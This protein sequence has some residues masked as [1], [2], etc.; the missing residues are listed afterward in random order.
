MEAPQIIISEPP[1]QISPADSSPVW[2]RFSLLC[3]L[4]L[5]AALWLEPQMAPICR[6]TAFQV[7]ALLGLAGFNPH[8]QGDLVALSGFTIRIVTECTSLYACLL[9]VAFVMA[10]PSSWGRTLAGL[11]MGAMV[12]TAVNLLR[13]AFVT[14][15][16]P[17]VSSLEFDILHVYL[18]QVAMLMLVVAAALVWLRWSAA[19]PAP[20]PFLLRAGFIATALFFPWVVVNRAYV[21]LLDNL[22]A[23]LFSL[24]IPGSQLLIP[25]PLAIYNHTFAVPL[26]LALILASRNIWTVNRFA[27]TVGGVYIIAGCHAMFRVSHVVWTALDVPEI[28]PLHQCIYLLSQFLLPFLLWIWL[29]GGFTRQERGLTEDHPSSGN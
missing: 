22:V 16:G 3:T 12:I 17:V 13:I 26:F 5:L 20:Y 11:L 25:R 7:G 9:Y 6:A 27:A 18:G 28:V 19:G 24:L 29:D 2:F 4:L 21:A 15:A 14:A 23:A 8:V 10:Q 1:K